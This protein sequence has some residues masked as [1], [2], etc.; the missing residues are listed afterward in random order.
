MDTCKTNPKDLLGVKKPQLW[1]I[2]GPGLVHL[3]LAFKNGADKY[4]AYNWREKKVRSTIY[5]DA[6]LRHIHSYLDGEDY[7]TDSK[8]HHL[9]HTA[10]CMMILLDAI[11]TGNL[12]D[13]RPTAGPTA[14][15]IERHKLDEET[16]LN[17]I[18]CT[19]CERGSDNCECVP[20][21]Y[22]WR[23]STTPGSTYHHNAPRS[24]TEGRTEANS[25]NQGCGS[26]KEES[27]SAGSYG[28]AKGYY[29]PEGAGKT[30]T[31]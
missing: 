13:D 1:L 30:K 10:A 23:T 24:P 4:G 2:P 20:G 9:A 18:V 26:P 25:T 17:T 29:R 27:L 11:E 7:A 3:A 8:L 21:L 28:S 6:A 12:I 19:N 5:V 14:E 16:P 31:V 15:L 22:P